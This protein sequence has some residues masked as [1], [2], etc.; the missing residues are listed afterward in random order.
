MNITAL[1]RPA[2]L[3]ERV[4][5]QL[6]ALIRGSED[7]GE[8]WLP[9]ERS[10]AAKLGVS[11]TVVRE[12]TKR[13]EQQGMLEI[14]HGTGIKI[15]DRL[16]RPLNDSLLLLL[17][18]MAERL[19]HLNDTRLS[20]E[21]DAAA[22][23][24]Q[25]AT[26]EQLRTLRRVQSQLEKAPNNAAAIEADMAAHHAIADA[27]GNPIYRLILDSLAEIGISSRL[28]TIG[29]IG[30]KT[31]VA[32]HEAIISA[33]EQRDPEAARAAMRLHIL[34]AGQDMDLPALKTGN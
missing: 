23:A 2:S 20:I 33:I 24:A 1:D 6:A 15:V 19:Q 27:S 32:H 8:R 14:Q 4:C 10:L 16:H 26:P 11:R 9:S 17:P 25:R 31:A 30:K 21:P 13:L 28:R 12:A 34:A 29:R 5:Q 3:V 18:D 7:D 22:F